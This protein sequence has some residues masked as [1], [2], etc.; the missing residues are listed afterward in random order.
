MYLPARET[1]YIVNISGCGKSTIGSLLL[2]NYTVRS[3]NRDIL[4]ERD[5]RYLDMSWV[6]HYVAVIVQ[7]YTGSQL[8]NGPVHRNVAL[9]VVGSGRRVEDVTR[10]EVVGARRMATLEGWISGLDKEYETVLGGSGSGKDEDGMISDDGITLSGAIKCITRLQN[11]A[12]ARTLIKDADDA[13]TLVSVVLGQCVV[14][15]AMMG[16]GLLWGMVWGWQLTL[17]DVAI[18][19]VFVC[20][21]GIQTGLV[22]RC[23]VRNKR[24]REEVAKVYY[25]SILNVRSIRAMSL[26]PILQAQ[27]DKAASTCLSTSIRGAFVEGCTY[28]VASALIYLA[29]ALLFYMVQVLNLVV[30][31]VT[32]GSQ[33]MAFTQKIAKSVQATTDLYALVQLS[34]DGTSEACGML[35]PAKMGGDLVLRDVDFAYPTTHEDA[36]LQGLSM[37]VRE[38]ECIALVGASGCG[39]SI[40]AT[41]LQR[42]YEPGSGSISLGNVQ[43]SSMDVHYFRDHV[44]VVSQHPN[45]FDGTIRENIAYGRPSMSDAEVERAARAANVH[46]FVMGLSQGYETSIGEN[47]SLP[48]GGQ[49]QRIQIARAL[50]RPSC[51]VLILD[52]C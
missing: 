47:G 14:V 17:V 2:D 22:G 43:L 23:E 41:L 16:P 44:A 49:A 52:E 11:V 45:L 6:R 51:K 37:S 40:L 13:R 10:E 30:F 27:F 50:G 18:G 15:T 24:A 5:I 42:L 12:Y 26:E 31:T 3:G 35:K 4:D 28:G 29:E 36:V 7:G 9:D 19:P 38:G 48:S 1:T 33:L 34:T 20:V 8:F 25:E 39:K 46:D 21:M 32:I